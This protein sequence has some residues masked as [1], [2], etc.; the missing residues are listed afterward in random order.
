MGCEMS[1]DDGR[2][3][4]KGGKRRRKWR[5]EGGAFL[6]L[7]LLLLFH[8]SGRDKKGKEGWRRGSPPSSLLQCGQTLAAYS[9]LTGAVFSPPQRFDLGDLFWIFRRLLRLFAAEA[10]FLSCERGT[11]EEKRRRALERRKRRESTKQAGR[12]GA[13]FHTWASNKTIGGGSTFL[14]S[15][16]G[17]VLEKVG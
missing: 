9:R 7:L 11:E 4:E 1:V 8:K 15:G 17:R 6:S 10:P 14:L 12:K 16:G 13:S 3:Y 5:G 2:T